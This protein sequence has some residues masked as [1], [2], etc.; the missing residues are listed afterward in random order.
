MDRLS[1]LDNLFLWLDGNRQPLH[2]AGLQIFSY[3]DDAGPHYISE[4][5]QYLRSFDAPSP[6][7]NQ[8]LKMR[9]SGRFWMR[10]EQF[11]IRHHVHH[12]VFPQP[13]SWSELMTF[14]SNE[15]GKH[16]DRNRPLWETCL[17]NAI[18]ERHFALYTKIHHSVM[19]GVSAIRMGTRMLCRDPA[20]RNLP[21]MWQL[22]LPQHAPRS[23]GQQLRSQLQA[24][25]ALAGNQARAIPV[26]ASALYQTVQR[27]RQEPELA[28]VFTAPPCRLTQPISGSRRFAAQAFS[29]TR[30]KA[31]ACR[32][33]ATLNDV[34]LA[35]CSGALRAYLQHY[36][37]LPARPLVAMVPLSLRHD[38]SMGGNQVATI[39][40]NLGTH[41]AQPLQRF[42][43]I[44]QSVLEGK[45]RFAGMTPEQ[46]LD[47]A[48]L[49]LAPTGF[50][51]LTGLMPNLM[52]FNV[53]ISNLQGPDEPCYWNGARLEHVFPV[54]AI[55]DHMALNITFIRYLD[56]LEFGVVGCRRTLPNLPRLLEDMEQALLELEAAVGLRPAVVSQAPQGALH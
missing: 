32:L 35:M 14:V 3:P 29:I 7:F 6:P 27:A 53:I 41:I 5:A 45:Q 24:V 21:P 40:A 42:E 13:L 17:I 47:Y 25:I 33:N 30:L 4:L 36:N 12:V 51:L 20:R 48:A 28:H 15:H 34:I 49:M 22:P 37:D 44:R 16:L 18:D 55:V 38:D 10:D 52:A 50:S 9:W 1:I 26:V 2:V 54:S 43:V 19:D 31:V 23:L 11:N 56:K 39:L 46:I 8:R